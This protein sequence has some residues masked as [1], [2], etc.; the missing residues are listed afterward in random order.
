MGIHWRGQKGHVGGDRRLTGRLPTHPSAQGSPT[1]SNVPVCRTGLPVQGA[2]VRP[3]HGPQSLHE[4]S[5]S[6]SLLPQKE[7]G[8]PVRV[9]RRLV[10]GRELSVR[11]R[12]QRTQ[13]A[14]YPPRAGLDR[15]REEVS[16][17]SNSDDP[18]PWS[19][20]RL[21][22]RGSPTLG[23]KDHCGQD[24]HATDL[25]TPRVTQNDVAPSPGTHGQSGRCSPTVQVTHAT[26][27][28]SP[29]EVRRPHRSGHDNTNPQ[30]GGNHSTPPM[31]A[32]PRQL[33]SR[34]TFHNRATNDICNDRRF[35]HRMGGSLEQPHS[36]G[37]VVPNRK[38]IPHQ[39][40]GDDRSQESSGNLQR[41][42]TGYNNH[43]LH[44]QHHSGGLHQPAGGHPLRE[45]LPASM[46]GDNSSRGFG[47]DPTS[48][49]HCGQAQRDG[50]RLVQ[51]AFR[52]Q[53]MDAG[54]RNL[55]Q[56]LRDLRKADDR[57]VRNIHKQ[58][59]PDLLFQTVPPPGLPHGCDVPPMGPLRG[60]RLPTA[61]H[62][63]AGSQKDPELQGQVYSNSPVLASQTLVRRD[64][65]TPHGRPSEPT[66]QAPPTVPETG[67]TLPP[68]HQGVAVSCLETVRSSLRQRGFS[69]AAAAMAAD[70]RRGTTAKT[71]DSRLR[72]FEQWCRPRQILLTKIS[73]AQTAEFLLSLFREGKQVST[74][75]NY[76][77]A[78]AAIHQGFPDGSTLG[79]NLDI[80][81]LIKGMANRRPRV[82]RLAPSWGLSAVL[83]ALAGPPYE[84][85]ANA[86]LAALTKKTLF[87][88]AVASA[89]RRSCL[90]A[91]T[92]KP[93][94]IRFE[95]HG[96]RMVPDPAFIAKNQA[97]TFLPG[98]IFIPEIKTL[99]S[100]AEDKRWCPVRALKWYLSRTEK[101]RQTTSLFILPRPPYT[102]ASKDTLSRWLVE[103]IRPFTTGAARPRAHD[104]RGISA[105]T[106]LFAGIPIEDILKAAAWKTPTTFVACYLTDTL[107]A[108]AA[109]GSA[110]M[111]GPAGNRSHPSGLHHRAV[112]LGAKVVR[113][114]VSEERSK[115]SKTYWFG[116]LRV[117]S[118]PVSIP[119]SL[120]RG[121]WDTAGRGSGRST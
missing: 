47:H 32:R 81:Q 18:V 117:T 37:N 89:R 74:I 106:A 57:P 67:N 28:A 73:I 99:S 43:G 82:R 103:T 118:L 83:H 54:T 11:G 60:L 58:Q 107:H 84:P 90:H 115:Y 120:P 13:N 50:R 25:V 14:P 69:E 80:A 33:E 92:T 63:R 72:K 109:F 20:T 85:M 65:P 95:G 52:P 88:I 105:S 121:R 10:G 78:I 59:A 39:Y 100:V 62:G 79:N 4:N 96:V 1:V 42:H 34:G 46:G 77:S 19:D 16:T 49:P 44:G 53:R 3:V 116:Y 12:R 29:P 24:D 66:R 119:A 45:A 113:R 61:L 68:G 110:V 8:H 94:H 70:A 93:N 64:S 56:N 51:G 9:P 26:P 76:R 5:G 98:D 48:F 6:G 22:R 36:L 97:L 38:I 102:S 87:L 21:L 101:L 55:Q 91:L 108:E 23:R 15:E 71:Y 104:I 17:I 35:T 86:S 30:V 112:P 75:K 114:Q 40:P 2:P 111:R 41:A 31:V 27:T 7:R